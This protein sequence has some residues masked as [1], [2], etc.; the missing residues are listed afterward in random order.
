MGNLKKDDYGTIKVT[1]AQQPQLHQG[2]IQLDNNNLSVWLLSD[3]LLRDKRLNP[4]ADLNI[5]KETLE[6]H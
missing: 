4:T 1:I 3:L 5:L 2:K 6:K